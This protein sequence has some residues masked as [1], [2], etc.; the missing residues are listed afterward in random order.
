VWGMV[1]PKLRVSVGVTQSQASGSAQR[2]QSQRQCWCFM[3]VFF[4]LLFCVMFFCMVCTI[5]EC[6]RR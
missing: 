4:P 1:A 2:R 6:I 5:N 3:I